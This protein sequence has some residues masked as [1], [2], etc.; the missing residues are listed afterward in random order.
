[1][2]C[3]HAERVVQEHLDGGHDHSRVR[4]AESVIQDVHEVIDFLLIGR[5]VMCCKLQ[6]LALCPFGKLL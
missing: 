4:V 2:G 1:M 3:W 5:S 6:N